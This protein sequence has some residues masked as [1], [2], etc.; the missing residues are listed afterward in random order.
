MNETEIRDR[1]TEAFGESSFPPDLT[2]RLRLGLARPVK[3]GPAPIF[4]FV[5]AVLVVAIVG[6]LVWTRVQ[7][8]SRPSPAVPP[9]SSSIPQANPVTDVVIPQYDL[10]QAQL[11]T[12]GALVTPLN[13]TSTDG[14]RTVTLIGAYADS[15]RIVLF[16]RS[17]PDDDSFPQVMVYDGSG[18][19]NASVTGG[20]GTIGD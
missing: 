18:L 15:S 5:A 11:P 10:D 8:A 12:S 16:L 13:L 14:G 20:R 2:H 4:G 1:V 19:L 3:R 6:T 9:I 7:S 17:L